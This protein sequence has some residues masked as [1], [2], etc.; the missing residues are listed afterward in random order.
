M[1]EHPKQNE[2]V[3]LR[4]FSESRSV[5]ADNPANP[6]CLDTVASGGEIEEECIVVTFFLNCHA[7]PN[8]GIAD[9]L[10]QQSP[11]RCG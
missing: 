5:M 8:P 2:G 4:G 3:F 7:D 1:V 9:L 11:S 10:L 6:S